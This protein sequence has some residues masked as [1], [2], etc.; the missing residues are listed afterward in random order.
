[1]SSS[2]NGPQK[3]NAYVASNVFNGFAPVTS[4]KALPVNLDFTVSQT[5][6]IDMSALHADGG[7]EFVQ[8]IYCDNSQNASSI[9]FSSTRLQFSITFPAYSQGF[10]TFMCENAPKIKVTSAN[11]TQVITAHIL[12]FPVATIITSFSA[13]DPSP[14]PDVIDTGQLAIATTGTAVQLPNVTL[15]NGI[16]VTAATSNSA[17]IYV[18][19]SNVQNQ[20][21]G[22]GNGYPL[23]PGQSMS[24]ST[25]NANTIWINGTAGNWVAYNGN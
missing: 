24:L 21:G 11:T 14:T 6:D 4:P 9:T 15:L 12:N 17:T 5:I 8:G 25:A 23:A 19:G 2:N 20:G 7:F 3:T 13:A 1:M 18:G 22:T 10:Q 16:V